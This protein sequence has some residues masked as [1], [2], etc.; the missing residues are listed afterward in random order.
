MPAAIEAARRAGIQVKMLT[1]DNVITATAVARRAGILP[2]LEDNGDGCGA[3]SGA[4]HAST[5]L[6]ISTAS[7]THPSPAAASQHPA[8]APAPYTVLRGEE[9][10]ALVLDPK[11]GGID[12]ARF[13]EV[14]SQLRVLARC[15]PQDKLAI[16][17]GARQCTDDIVAVTGDGTNDAPALRAAHVGFAMRQGT[18]IAREAADIVLLDNNFASIVSAALWGRNV[19]AS[20]T[21]FLQFQ[22]T[23]NIV[24]VVTA[25]AGSV[26]HTRSPLS[27]V[28]MLWVNLMMDSLAGLALASGT[29]SP[30]LLERRPFGRDHAF[31]GP[32]STSRKHVLGQAAFQLLVMAG[33][34][35][36]GP[37]LLHVTPGEAVP[38]GTPSLH[39]TIVFNTFVW[40]QLFNQ[41]NSR[42]TMDATGLLEGL[43]NARLF[44]AILATEAA[45][46]VLIVQYGG[47]MMQTEPLNAGQWAFCVGTGALS[48]V[49][50]ELLKQVGNS[51]DDDD[52]EGRMAGDEGGRPA[53][54]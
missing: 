43:G 7:S 18:D 38:R 6:A 21:R 42:L 44:C 4:D 52:D 50:H 48:L 19:Y 2:A 27:A 34:I 15:T 46:Q 36:A 41:L 3:G 24:A 9:F 28:Q 10:R 16:V 30:R 53:G 33:L 20:I 1:G 5:Q 49:V 22:L 31:L 13:R 54:D 8:A 51:D 25:V 29:P 23:T 35:F 40:L 14:W 47:R 26:A 39:H 17:M 37:G 12:C 11:D 45:I 32:R